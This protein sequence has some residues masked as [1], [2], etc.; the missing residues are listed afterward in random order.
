MPASHWQAGRQ[1]WAQARCGTTVKPP[2]SGQRARVP[3]VAAAAERGVGGEAEGVDEDVGKWRV[4]ARLEQ[5][6]QIARAAHGEARP[7]RVEAME[8]EV[9][10]MPAD[11]VV[12]EEARREREEVGI[13]HEGVGLL[14]EADEELLDLELD[15]DVQQVHDLRA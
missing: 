13:R 15:A 3:G 6:A 2:M 7:E 11:A 8:A 14:V 4:G 12:V 1:A 10:E 5:L 9:E